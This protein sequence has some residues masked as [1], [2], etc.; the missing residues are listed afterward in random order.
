MPVVTTSPLC[1]LEMQWQPFLFYFPP[2]QIFFISMLFSPIRSHERT[3][4]FFVQQW[5]PFLVVPLAV[6]VLFWVSQ[7]FASYSRTCYH[8][9]FGIWIPHGQI[10]D[11][12]WWGD[13]L[14]F[15]FL[16]RV[17]VV[18]VCS[19]ETNILTNMQCLWLHNHHT[20]A[21]HGVLFGVF[22]CV[23]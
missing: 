23:K 11:T 16:L 21:V 14:V 4:L 6:V 3:R 12:N 18:R 1:S 19:S 20:T 9:C 8:R 13:Q 10:N 22:R 15:L 7:P 2:L 17:G 5:F